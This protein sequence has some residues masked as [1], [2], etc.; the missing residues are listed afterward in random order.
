MKK[1][2]VPS[3]KKPFLSKRNT[4]K[5]H[6]KLNGFYPEKINN[7]NVLQS[8]ESARKL[9]LIVTLNNNNNNNIVILK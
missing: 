7:K 3:T 5:F 8:R 4:A 1:V 9:N 6:R 2:L